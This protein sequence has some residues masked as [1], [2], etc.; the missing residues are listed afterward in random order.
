L[1]KINAAR[2]RTEKRAP[3][4]T[5]FRVSFTIPKEQ[6]TETLQQELENFSNKT[7]KVTMREIS[8]PD[9]PTDFHIE[10]GKFIFVGKIENVYRVLG[11]LDDDDVLVACR[12]YDSLPSWC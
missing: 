11:E 1:R 8:D 2:I 12:N 6:V 7:L 5:N 4:K 9:T 10:E 3:I